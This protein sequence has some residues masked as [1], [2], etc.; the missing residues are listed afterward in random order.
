MPDPI[1]ADVYAVGLLDDLRRRRFRS[2]R[3]YVIHH[4]RRRNWRAIRNYFRNGWL[5]EHRW[6][7]S[8]NAGWGWTKRASARRAARAHR[9]VVSS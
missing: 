2:G 8:H 1:D 6:P 4:L 7:C 5:T 9:R 3:R